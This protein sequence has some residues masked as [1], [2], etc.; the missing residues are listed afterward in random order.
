MSWVIETPVKSHCPG[1]W[2][3][4]PAVRS[5][6]LSVVPCANAVDDPLV[7]L[8]VAVVPT[9]TKVPTDGSTVN[10]PAEAA[11]LKSMVGVPA[12][13]SVV[14]PE[15]AAIDMAQVAVV[16]GLVTRIF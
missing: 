8:V 1:A 11:P 13:Q 7:M 4:A 2:A 16:V 15:V 9:P 14:L 10:R 3:E 12:D 6:I 5:V